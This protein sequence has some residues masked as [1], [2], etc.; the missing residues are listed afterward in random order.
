MKL[1]YF[2][3]VVLTV[4]AQLFV[5]AAFAEIVQ[6]D[7]DAPKIVHSPINR[8]LSLDQDLLIVATVTDNMRVETV[9]LFYRRIGEIQYKMISMGQGASKSTY[10]IILPAE[11]FSDSGVEYYIQ[12][13]DPAGNTGLYGFS[14]S[15]VKIS[16][17]LS[18]PGT[19]DLTLPRQDSN[20]KNKGGKKWLW[21]GLGALVL[22]AVAGGGGGGSGGG[23]ETGDVDVVGPVP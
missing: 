21:I 8:P 20:E 1:L 22:G 3:S 2:F 12:A 15:P 17:Q 11:L 13:S 10:T 18:S 7:D 19:S 14:F 23:N 9:K 5:S 16:T 6:S 4:L